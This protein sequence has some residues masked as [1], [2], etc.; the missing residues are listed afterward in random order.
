MF[1][2]KVI[3]KISDI[4]RNN[5]TRRIVA[6]LLLCFLIHLSIVLFIHY[7]QFRPFG[8]GADYEGYHKIGKTIA[9]NFHKGDF[10]LE[11]LRFGHDFPVVVGILYYFTTPNILVGLLFVT[12]L[13]LISALS[14]YLI[15]LELGGDEKTALF[16]ALAI[17]LYPSYGYFGSLLLKD[18][19]IIPLVL[20]SIFLIIKSIRKFNWTN[21]FI[22]FLLCLIIDYLRFY[23]GYALIFSFVFSW[24]FSV[25]IKNKRA[26]ALGIILTILIGFAPFLIG[27]GYFG[28][29][30]VQDFLNPG[31]ITLYREI[32]YNPDSSRNE[33]LN[34]ISEGEQIPDQDTANLKPAEYI[35]SGMGSSFVVETGLKQGPVKFVINSIKSAMYALFGP[36]PWQFRYVR[37]AISLIETMPWYIIMLSFFIGIFAK[38]RDRNRK[39]ILSF[40]IK[41]VPLWSFAILAIGA[42][43]LFIN[44]YGIIVRIRIP[45]VISLLLTI[46]LFFNKQISDIYEKIFSYWRGR[47]YWL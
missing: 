19:L 43:S 14:L 41:T 2:R 1:F 12:L 39:E 9:D 25:G 37:H 36:F 5:K 28:Y 40:F 31:K 15:V 3:N 18:S 17:N 47:V 33:T 8:G 23:I 32:A 42:L 38:L 46:V 34:P 20:V 29:Y 22:L 7:S 26:M 11:G 21:F 13:F 27:D 10:S 45:I 24:F 6:V 35:P 44:N 16:L 4:F 30:V